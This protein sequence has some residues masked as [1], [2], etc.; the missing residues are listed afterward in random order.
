MTGKAFVG[1][2]DSLWVFEFGSTKGQIF[3]PGGSFA[4]VLTVPGA[5]V[6]GAAGPN[7]GASAG[8]IYAT[9]R[10]VG[11]Y[12]DAVNVDTVNSVIFFDA[13]AAT[14]D[15][16]RIFS[17]I[18]GTA[19]LRSAGTERDVPVIS[20]AEPVLAP[21][22]TVWTKVGDTRFERHDTAGTPRQLI[23]IA[24]PG[25]PPPLMT[26][27]QA[28]SIR[29]LQARSPEQGRGA[30]GAG[31]APTLL[32]ER[33]SLRL[34]G[35]SRQS[36]LAVDADGLLWLT[37]TIRAPGADTIKVTKDYLSPDEAPGEA[38]VPRD[39]EDRLKHT[40]VE[41]IDPKRGQIVARRELPFDGFPMSP[42]FVG[43]V[44]QDA[45]GVYVTSVY[46]LVL[47]RP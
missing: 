21:D 24:R 26:L 20:R 32:S 28:D 13:A 12:M 41:V 46:H 22:G 30:R 31:Q 9:R 3:T 33:G 35:Q 47:R 27:A 16:F 6:F 29:Q 44:T 39:I 5:R 14:R 18:V 34:A 25:Q 7:T 43:R 19:R 15:S 2:G 45:E 4:R 23:G 40:V 37:R 36:W 8:R 42:G 38:T 1:P 17:A 11:S 10:E